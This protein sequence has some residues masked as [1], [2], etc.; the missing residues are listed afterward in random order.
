MNASQID[1]QALALGIFCA[2]GLIIGA[3][4][5]S[6]FLWQKLWKTSRF[7]CA[8]NETFLSLACGA[9]VFCVE[10]FVFDYDLQFY[11]FACLFFS[12][13]AI[14]AIAT[15]LTKGHFRA[16]QNSVQKFKFKLISKLK[17]NSFVAKLIK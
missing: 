11:H 6:L 13:A 4:F 17:N 2:V 12:S 9:C 14:F 5:F 8:L 15:K 10:F 3:M 7:F 16:M 1:T